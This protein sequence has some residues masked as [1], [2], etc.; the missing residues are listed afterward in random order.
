[1]IGPLALAARRFPLV[2]R[3][4]PACKP[5]S[6]RIDDLCARAAMADRDR[7]P[8]VATAVFNLAALLASDCGVPELARTWS[9]RLVRAALEYQ[10]DWRLALEPVVNL[11]RLRTRAGDGSGAWSLLENL[12]QAVE[13][14]ADV[15][16]DGIEIPAARLTNTPESHRELRTWLWTVLLSS[17]AHALTSVGRWHDAR[18]RL[19]RYNGIGERMLDGRQIAVL[20]HATSG[21]Y[22][23]ALKLVRTTTSGEPWE[24]AVIACLDLLCDPEPNEAQRRVALASY[25][26]LSPVPTGLVV[27]RNRLGL[28]VIDA[29]GGSAVPE[30]KMVTTGLLRSAAEDGYAARDLL[31]YDACWNEAV[32]RERHDLAVVVAACGLDSGLIPEALLARLCR[33]LDAAENVLVK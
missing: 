1:M 7:D 6:V 19:A 10:Q 32:D 15:V 21:E 20:A 17:G 18:E 2:A 22:D 29:F 13:S 4:R 12:Y 9:H 8:V 24:C 25:S 5:L 26:A 23:T 3:P 14:R 33:A 16:I 27:F 31:A 30:V 28:S 11:A